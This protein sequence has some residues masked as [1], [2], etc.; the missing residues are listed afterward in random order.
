MLARLNRLLDSHVQQTDR[1][2]GPPDGASRLI[3]WLL[4]SWQGRFVLLDGEGRV[5]S[6]SHAA[7]D[8]L[9][10]EDGARLREAVSRVQQG[11]TS[12]GVSLL[13]R[14]EH[15]TLV[16]LEP[17]AAAPTAPPSAE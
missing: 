4:D 13:R 1:V 9:A 2:E 15:W 11:V 12:E 10:S 3:P 6:A 17:L 8:M 16:T 7:L 5:L 14:S